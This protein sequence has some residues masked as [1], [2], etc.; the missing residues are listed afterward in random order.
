[1]FVRVKEKGVAYTMNA[2]DLEKNHA[3]TQWFVTFNKPAL[4]AT[5]C[6]CGADEDFETNMA[7]IG[8]FWA[9][10][11]VSDKHQAQAVFAANADY[12]VLPTGSDQVPFPGFASPIQEGA[13]VHIITRD[14]GKAKKGRKLEA[15]LSE[16]DG[17]CPKNG[18]MDVQFSINPSPSCV[19]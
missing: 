10:G 3:Y 9:T 6:E 14:H 1:L 18:C 12:Y 7:D 13:E 15:Q 11:R 17:G 4:C 2:S 19:P 5:P 16:F 8:V